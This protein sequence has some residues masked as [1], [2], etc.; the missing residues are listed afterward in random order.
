MREGNRNA[1]FWRAVRHLLTE[2]GM[3]HW[4]SY[5]A[6]AWFGTVGLMGADSR[7]V[8]KSGGYPVPG[9][10][11]TAAQGTGKVVTV[12]GDDGSYAFHGLNDGIWTMHVEFV[13]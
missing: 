5:C 13:T 3:G 6:C 1:R 11:V 4:I 9:V 7:G 8:V 12:T 2:D 10:I